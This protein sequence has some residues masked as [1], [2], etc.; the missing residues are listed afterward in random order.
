MDLKE[1]VL[2]LF[3]TSHGSREGGI[4]ICNGVSAEDGDLPPAE[5]RSCP[6]RRGYLL[7]HRRR[8][9]LLLRRFHR[10]AEDGHNDDPDRGRLPA[11]VVRLRR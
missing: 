11:H 1:D 6:R 10:A 7:A 3:L 2:V 8:F 9:R 4:Y 5:V